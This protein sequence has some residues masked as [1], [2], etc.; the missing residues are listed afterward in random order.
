MTCVDGLTEG[1]ELDWNNYSEVIMNHSQLTPN[2]SYNK[3]PGVM[4]AHRSAL[5]AHNFH[6][7]LEEVGQVL[8]RSGLQDVLGISLLHRH[9]DLGNGEIMVQRSEQ[10]DDGGIALVTAKVSAIDVSEPLCPTVWRV[11]TDMPVEPLEYCL[12]ADSGLTNDF[13]VKNQ[14]VFADVASV[15]KR[16][17]LDELLGLSLLREHVLGDNR[18]E[19]IAIETTD[20]KRNAN[21]V[22][23]RKREECVDFITTL[24]RF[25]VA[26]QQRCIPFKQC[27]PRSP[28]HDITPG[29]EFVE[30]E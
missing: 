6:S 25:N 28:G 16:N 7:A 22:T 5:C 21:V 13:F 20:L 17:G 2:W 30:G 15:L 10:L 23:L 8:E 11:G 24:W 27:T 12:G 18:G 9:N 4:K 29:H 26:E 14:H 3:L 19:S 1:R